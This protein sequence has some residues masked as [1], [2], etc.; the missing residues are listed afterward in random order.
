MRNRIISSLILAGSLLVAGA[1]LP[2]AAE[3]GGGFKLSLEPLTFGV[4]ETDVDNNSAK[5]EEYRDLGSGFVIPKLYLEGVS[6]DGN[7]YLSFHGKHVLRNDAR[8]GFEYGLAGKYSLKLD[9]NKIPHNFGYDSHLLWTRTAPGVYSLADGVQ[10]ALQGAITNQF[11]TNRAGIT[12]DFL[13]NL[14]S[15]Y[16]AASRFVDVGL[17]RD[18]T[19]AVVELAKSHKLSWNFEYFHENRNGTRP[20]GSSFGFNNVTE[21][22]EPIDYD[23]TQVGV[24]GTY[25]SKTGALSFGYRYSKFE[26]NISTLYWDNPFRLTDATDSGAYSSPGSGSIGGAAV[27]VAD[28]APDNDM[29]SLFASGRWRL[30]GNWF[31]G[32]N[33]QYSKMKQ[34]DS[35]LA[36]TT[37][38][39]IHGE[40]FDGS[41]F[42][43]TNPANLPAR[44]ADRKVDVLNFNGDLGTRFGDDWSL[45]FRAR[46]YDYNNKSP[47]IEFPGYVRY[48]AVWEE[49]A[50]ITVPYAYTSQDLGAE[51]G[52]D[53]TDNANLSLSYTLKSWDR[54]FREVKSSDEDVIKAS[55]DWK[56]GQ[57]TTL[58][59]S[60]ERGDRSIDGYEPEAQ[61]ATFVEP[62]GVNNQPTLRK[63]AQAAREYT[64]YSLMAQFLFSEA[65]NM[66]V[67]VTSRNDDYPDSEF[68]LTGDEVTQYSIDLAWTP[69]ETNTFYVFGHISDRTVD[70]ADRQSGATPSTRTIDSWFVTF[71]EANDTFGL[72][73][74][75]KADKW[76]FDLSGSYIKSDGS[77][78][79]TAFPGGLPLASPGAGLPARTAAQDI[80]NYEDFKLTT[81]KV[82]VDYAITGNTKVG[83]WYLYED[84]SADSFIT[85]GLV[86]YLPGALILN[87][88]NGDYQA[89]LF[90]VTMSVAF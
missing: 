58:R 56:L 19:T 4:L 47:R 8:Y 44:T 59:A 22:P 23:T 53:F 39:A 20:Y 87:G 86:N 9:Y 64:A 3:G 46:Y 30:G 63:Y 89:N 12:Y 61:E 10:G 72:G 74:T 75:K 18:R 73:W 14:I 43:P 55:L 15:P 27:G 37:N 1:S 60:I 25:G 34:D 26:N 33:L 42:D 65:F 5:F 70:Q 76:T 16:V 7:R 41:L 28:L 51:L 68:G 57:I 82:K 17:Q 81:A 40:N 83:I 50:R 11:N 79:F 71:D 48:H 31:A 45:T 78:D 84:Y 49:I 29:A 66:S 52:W 35:L 2:A 6:E 13:N 77:A 32:G 54:E 24:V 90:A 80:G 62:E 21:L 85:E 38:T 69:D 36:Y 88:N 67:G